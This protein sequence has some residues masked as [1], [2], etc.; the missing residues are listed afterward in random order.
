MNADAEVLSSTTRMP[1]NERENETESMKADSKDRTRKSTPSPVGERRMRNSFIS[2]K[3][4]YR[5]IENKM[6]Q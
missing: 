6:L 4:F 2:R 3:K 1:F 5:M